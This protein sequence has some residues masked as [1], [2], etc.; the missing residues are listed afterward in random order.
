MQAFFALQLDNKNNRR[1][2]MQKGEQKEWEATPQFSLV[3][4]TINRKEEVDKFLQ[5][6][7]RQTIRGF[8]VIIVDQNK[9]GLLDDTIANWRNSLIIEHVKVDFK[10]LSKARN[11][12]IKYIKGGLT[13]FPD[14]DCEY[15]PSTLEKAEIFLRQNPKASIVVGKQISK[16]CDTNDSLLTQ[17]KEIKCSL[18]IFKSKAISFT[19]FA[20]SNDITQLGPAFFDE[21]LGVGAGTKWGSGEET[22]FLIRAHKLGLTIFKQPAI[23]I[24]HP[25]KI[26]S[27]RRCLHYGLGRYKVVKKNKLGCIIYVINVLQPL[28]RLLLQ[29]EYHFLLSHICTALG[30]SGLPLLFSNFRTR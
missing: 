9:D 3:L 10:G 5:S 27:P 20:R 1:N 29:S 28:V 19:I 30:R 18:D 16:I 17:D 24:F 4:C 12:G 2:P 21:R 14:D 25:E 15:Q 11:F 23:E 7:A 8:E 26:S 13:A 6:L 22:D